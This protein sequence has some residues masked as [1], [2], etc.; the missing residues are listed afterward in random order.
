MDPIKKQMHFMESKN[1][2]AIE[3]AITTMA[4]KIK[5]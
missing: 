3:V 2:K 1:V 4:L 5:G